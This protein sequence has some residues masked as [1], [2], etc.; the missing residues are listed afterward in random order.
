VPEG[1]LHLRREVFRVCVTSSRCRE[2][3]SAG[4][5]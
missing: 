1:H 3:V 4:I 5:T 2:S